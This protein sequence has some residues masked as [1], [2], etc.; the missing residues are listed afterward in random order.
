[1]EEKKSI[2]VSLGGSLIVPDGIDQEFLQQFKNFVLKWT[3]RGHRFFII[4]GGGKT[5]RNY[6]LAAK[7]LGVSDKI[8]LDQ[9]GIYATCIN[10]ELLRAFFGKIAYPA[11]IADYSKKFTT[12]AKVI[13]ASGWKPGCSTDLDAIY[14]A[15]L[16]GSKQVIN[17]SNIDCLYDKDP[18]AFAD[19][20][21]IEHLTFAELLK[22]TGKIWSPGANTPFD[23]IASQMAQK[24]KIEVIIANGKNL[25]NL[26]NILSGQ[27]FIGTT[28]SPK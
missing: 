22:I 24:E 21:P 18:R 5:A 25:N 8:N 28:V 20:K 14:A 13:V 10:A 23:P 4:S 12:D 16:V 1:M 15:K 7:D 11:I 9:I 17:L 27:P 19:A 2:V 3:R 26:D 6:Q